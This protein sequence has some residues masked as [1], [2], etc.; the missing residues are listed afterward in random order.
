ILKE[1]FLIPAQ[2]TPQQLA[3]DLNIS[4]KETKEIIATKRDL[5]KD[6][7]TRLALYFHTTPTF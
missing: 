1:E 6:I 5:T 4:K 7:A 3:H 2:I